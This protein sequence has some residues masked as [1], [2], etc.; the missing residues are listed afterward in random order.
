[1]QKSTLAFVLLLVLG[2]AFVAKAYAEKRLD[3]THEFQVTEESE[4]IEENTVEQDNQQ[5]VDEQNTE[6]VSSYRTCSKPSKPRT[7][8]GDFV[9]NILHRSRNDIFFNG[10][11]R[12][13]LPRQPYSNKKYLATGMCE[14]A[15]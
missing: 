12:F 13:D 5:K 8:F 3:E 4:N 7:S 14:S 15:S 1:M 2:F 11:S 10:P 6:S 9:H